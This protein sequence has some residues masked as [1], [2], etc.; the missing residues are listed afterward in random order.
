MQASFTALCKPEKAAAAA[1]VSF[2]V[3]EFKLR[4][5]ISDVVVVDG[6]S[7]NDI[8]IGLEK[9]GC[10]TVEFKFPKKGMGLSED[11]GRARPSCDAGGKPLNLSFTH[12]KSDAME[13]N[14]R[15][16]LDGTLVIDSANKVSVNHV[17]EAGIMKLGYAYEH[18]GLTTFEPSYD[19]GKNTWDFAVSRRVYGDDVIRATYEASSKTLG[20]EWSQGSK[21]NGSIKILASVNLADEQ[22]MPRLCAEMTWDFEMRAPCVFAHRQQWFQSGRES[23]GWKNTRLPI[24]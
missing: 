10:F 5:S 4:A 22:K 24:Y 19:L 3:R 12:T 17:P 2:K 21:P 1:T 15:T 6:P 8:S 23:Y 13:G 11:A 18:R 20:V 7:V 16:M 14:G 9:P